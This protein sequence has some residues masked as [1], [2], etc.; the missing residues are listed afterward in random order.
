[1][2]VHCDIVVSGIVQGV[3]FRYLVL[4]KSRKLYL[5]GFV[6]N[7]LDGTVAIVIEG[8]RSFIEELISF[9][10]VGPPNSH[11]TNISLSWSNFTGKFHS[12]KII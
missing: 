12:F 5:K 7:N 10:R 1:M 8:E 11:V 4:Q 2:N 6:T 3:G 9:A